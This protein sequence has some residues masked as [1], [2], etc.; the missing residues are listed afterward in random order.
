M[1]PILMLICL[2][3][4]SVCYGQK[5]DVLP[6]PDG[7]PIITVFSNQSPEAAQLVAAFDKFPD[8]VDVRT[9]CQFFTLTAQD[10]LYAER[11]AEIIP[12]SRFPGVMV[13]APDGGVVYLATGDSMPPLEDLDDMIGAFWDAYRSAKQLEGG[14][15]QQS[16][17]NPDCPDGNCPPN[18]NSQPQERIILPSLL[19]TI[20]KRPTPIRDTISWAIWVLVLA[21]VAVFL[22]LMG[23][24][25]LAL[26]VVIAVNRRTPPE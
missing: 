6:A 16:T 25:V 7:K 20:A 17:S 5:Q 11:W 3:I 10:P 26:I 23:F 9:R 22:M 15:I 13:Q 21:V 19:D 8:L 2:M 24:A 14:V 4:G 18:W 1:R 12:A